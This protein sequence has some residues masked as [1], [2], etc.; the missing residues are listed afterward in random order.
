MLTSFFSIINKP[1]N[2][3]IILLTIL[4]SGILT[5][6]G[7]DIWVK[8]NAE[9]KVFTEV[10]Q[11][12]KKR[13]GL[14]LGTS[15]FLKNGQENLYYLYRIRAAVHLYQNGKISYVLISGDNSQKGYNEP[16]MMKE[17][18]IAKG[19]PENR[20]YL[21]YA[22]FRTLDSVVR[23]YK[24][25]GQKEFIVISQKFHNERAIFLA[26]SYDIEVIGFNAKDVRFSSGFKTVFRE[27]LA[28]V[29][30]MLDLI[31]QV[32]PKFLGEKIE[33]K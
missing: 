31:A 8:A 25:F 16:Q 24:I 4:V 13:V 2:L 27:K 30:M 17:D 14:L 11:I 29:K 22:G 19:I 5:V 1:K 12:Q 10:S 28:R 15:K 26:E 9:G 20:I 3:F 6:L 33:I 7:I 21:D 23:A 18:L 32:Q